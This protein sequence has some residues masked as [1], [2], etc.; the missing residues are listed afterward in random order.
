ML[1]IEIADQGMGIKDGVLKSLEEPFSTTKAN[2]NGLGLAIVRLVC[3]FHGGKF[4]L[5]T[6]SNEKGATA[7]V[8]LPVSFTG[9]E[10]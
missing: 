8:L 4:S 6:N 3:K 9:A 1:C 7:K 2:G 10:Q 5:S